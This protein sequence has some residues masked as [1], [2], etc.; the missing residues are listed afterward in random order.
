MNACVRAGAP[1]VSRLRFWSLV[2]L[3]GASAAG[4]AAL[5]F[6]SLD[7]SAGRFERPRPGEARPAVEMY[8]EDGKRYAV[9]EDTEAAPWHRGLWVRPA[10]HPSGNSFAFQACAGPATAADACPTRRSAGARNVADRIELVVDGYKTDRDA[11]EIKLGVGRYFA[12]DLM[13]G[14]DTEAPLN[15]TLLQQVYQVQRERTSPPF[16]IFLRRD[17][18]VPRRRDE[19]PR[20]VP[21]QLVMFVRDDADRARGCS[22]FEGCGTMV[23]GEPIPVRRGEWTRMVLGLRP[24]ALPAI[25]RVVLWKDHACLAPTTPPD[26]SFRGAWGYAAGDSLNRTYDPAFDQ[27]DVRVGIYRRQQPRQLSVYFDEIR[28]GK[29]LAD[30]TAAC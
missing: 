8:V 7:G 4:F 13:L 24:S 23:G 18:D 19:D 1:Y 15:W 5:P 11:E 3:L 26:A 12:F 22:A 2:V 29:T 20:Q 16:A 9:Y 25:G 30:V 27:F 10:G 17:P 28:L 6:H 14:T 21:L